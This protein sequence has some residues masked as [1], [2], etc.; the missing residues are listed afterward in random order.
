MAEW[1]KAPDL[2][3]GKPHKGFVGSNPTPAAIF[4]ATTRMVLYSRPMKHLTLVSLTFASLSVAA[5]SFTSAP[6]E[7][8]AQ[9][10]PAADDVTLGVSYQGIVSDAGISIYMQGSH[11]LTMPDDSFVL[12]QS[13]D[14]DL[15]AYLGKEV[16]IYGDARN[17]VEGDLTV[18]TVTDIVVL[19]EGSASS[20]TSS[21]MSSLSS[22]LTSSSL[23]ASSIASSKAK[24]SVPRSSLAA[25]SVRPAPVASSSS[26]D[27]HTSRTQA[28]AKAN[29]A[30]ANWTR[31]VCAP[32]AG[33]CFPI[34]KNWYYNSFGATTSYL[35]HVEVSSEPIESL[36]QGPLVVNLVAGA[37]ANS[38]GVDGQVLLKGDMIVGYKDWNGNH[39]EVVAPAA[40]ESAV[41]YLTSQITESPR[42]SA[43]SAATSR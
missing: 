7:E 5:C 15:D 16:E 18:V 29:M 36:G 8:V 39:F 23:A 19:S 4:L 12:L 1:S 33:F 20:I 28:M 25:S 38:G 34:H 21:E 41:R 22:E 31:M 3:S 26:L 2:K 17:S 24:S 40:L 30:P 14:I 42:S 6:T 11:R 32:Q 27:A 37:S 9:S 10:S 43:A 35:W 13:D